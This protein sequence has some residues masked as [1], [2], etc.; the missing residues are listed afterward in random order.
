MGMSE[1]TVLSYFH[2]DAWD[3]WNVT[4]SLRSVCNQLKDPNFRLNTAVEV[5]SHFFL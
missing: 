4:S 1:K 5:R 3:L 2:K